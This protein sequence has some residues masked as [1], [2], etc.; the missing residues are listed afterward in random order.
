MIFTATP[1]LWEKMLEKPLERRME[2]A[3]ADMVNFVTQYNTSIGNPARPCATIAE[4]DFM[5][6]IRRA[7]EELPL[8]VKRKLEPRLL[9]IFFMTDLGSSAIMDVIAR[10][11][12]EL[13]GAFVA[14]DVNIFLHRKANE[15]ASWRDNTPFIPTPGFRLETF[16][17][18]EAED[19]R[20]SALQYLLLHEFGHVLAAGLEF[21]PDHWQDQS[22]IKET[23]SYSFLPLSWEVQADSK[24]ASLARDDFPFRQKVAYYSVPQILGSHA[25]AIYQDLGKTAFPTLYAAT[26]VHEDFAECFSTYVHT[27]ML[28]KRHEINVYDNGKL[29]VTSDNFWMSTRSHE[30]AAFFID[31]FDQPPSP[32]SPRQEL[33]ATQESLELIHQAET[34]FIGLAPFLRMSIAD[35]DLKQVALDLLEKAKQNLENANLWMNLSTAM[36][37]INLRDVGMS[38]QEQALLMQRI[39]HLSPTGQTGRFKVLVLMVAGGISANTPLDCLLE[40]SD[41]DLVYYYATVDAPLPVNVPAHDALFV[42]IDDGESNRPIL[43]ALESLLSNWDKP[44]INAPQHI[45]NIERVK[46]SELLQ[47]IPG[48]LMPPTGQVT[49]DTLEKLTRSAVSESDFFDGCRFPIIL[50]P[51][52]SHAGRDLVCIENIQRLADYLSHVKDTGFYVSRFIDYSAAGDGLFRKYRIVMIAGQP[53]PCHMGI[54]SD[55][56]IHY[57]NAGMYDDAEKRA[58]EASFMD[59]FDDFARRH[60]KALEAVYQRSKLDYFCIDCSETREGELLIFEIGN[61]MVVHAMDPEDMF[62]YKQ[63]HMKK[64]M[65]AFEDFLFSLNGSQP[66]IA[67]GDAS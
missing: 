51:V 44:V 38:V 37:S 62:P 54:S 40:G 42:A 59:N 41:I 3:P 18:E 67:H 13:I 11:N 9:G 56:M 65:H 57:V 29:A 52:G 5:N 22:L 26:S 8:L 16:I 17:A 6:D 14:I 60:A 31:F 43:Q 27:V 28:N 55:W 21:M 12:G 48:L 45:P 4:T 64:V 19:N 66:I 15:W 7:I 1:S 39:Y 50:R 34:D 24:I 46:A 25:P 36:F 30:K 2:P 53:F 32:L 49:L 63:V 58:E 61:A 23:M 10:V 20:K 47:E 33:K 35:G